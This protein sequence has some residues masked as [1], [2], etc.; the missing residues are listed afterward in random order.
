MKKSLSN[1]ERAV[2]S[3]IWENPNQ[4]MSGIIETMGNQ[5][6][7]KYNTY[8]SYV[9]RL[10]E[11]GFAGYKRLGRD[12]FYYPLV[13]K[14]QCFMEESKDLL[15]RFSSHSAKDLL[16]YM[17]RDSDLSAQDRDEL[18]ALLDDLNKE[19]EKK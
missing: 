7:W 2:M 11:K 1:A 9:G 12:N 17:I 5:M 4:T 13:E 14:E 6:D 16:V 15:D 10:C 18:K 3:A 8:V 19:G